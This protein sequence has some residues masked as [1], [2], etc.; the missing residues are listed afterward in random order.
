LVLST[1]TQ[2]LERLRVDMANKKPYSQAARVQGVLR[3]LGAR[4][5]ITISELA[6]VLSPKPLREEIKLDLSRTLFQY[7]HQFVGHEKISLWRE[8]CIRKTQSRSE[9]L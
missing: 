7:K 9:T 3:T 1:S 2:A 4:H 8:R 5:G 6:E